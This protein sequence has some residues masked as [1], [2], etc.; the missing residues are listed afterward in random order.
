MGEN[1]YGR[2]CVIFFLTFLEKKI[3]TG[4]PITG[5][6]NY[7]IVKKNPGAAAPGPK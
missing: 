1:R 2:F 6:K 5:G 3:F 4:I 7:G